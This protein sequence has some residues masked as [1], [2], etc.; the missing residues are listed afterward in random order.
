MEKRMLHLNPR[1]G[2][3]SPDNQH[4]FAGVAGEEV[5]E[6]NP[7]ASSLLSKI[8]GPKYM[9]KE[10]NINSTSTKHSFMHEQG[11]LPM[12]SESE[13][14]RFNSIESFGVH[15]DEKTTLKSPEYVSPPPG[16][17]RNLFL[18]PKR[19]NSEKIFNN[20]TEQFKSEG[21]NQALNSNSMPIP[22]YYN[23]PV[24]S[25]S[26]VSTPPPFEYQY[27]YYPQQYQIPFAQAYPQQIHTHY[28][29]NTMP[30]DLMQNLTLEEQSAQ[31]MPS[32]PA[33][34]NYPQIPPMGVFQSPMPNQGSAHFSPHSTLGKKKFPKR[35]SQ[36]KPQEFLEELPEKKI[37]K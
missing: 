18:E 6:E 27:Y 10:S 2:Y 16:F 13:G 23:Y 34:P 1:R 29:T 32:Y 30:E 36:F 14:T 33:Y 19:H 37:M 3:S 24:N 9:R 5:E 26:G 31:Y 8:N 22:Q 20:D 28:S 7:L 4:F 12:K 17:I 35:P 15:E 21:V 25:A 11:V